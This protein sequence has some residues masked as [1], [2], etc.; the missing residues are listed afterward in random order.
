MVHTLESA[1]PRS[2]VEPSSRCVTLHE[3]ELGSSDP[4]QLNGYVCTLGLFVSNDVRV[5]HSAY[6]TVK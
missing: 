3:V 4:D 2:G 1:E 5:T 6:N